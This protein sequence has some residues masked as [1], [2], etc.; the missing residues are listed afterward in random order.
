MTS[1]SS[2]AELFDAFE[3]EAFRL[4]TLDDYSQSGN[5]DAYRAFLA[6]EEKPD[7][8][9]SAWLNEVSRH[10]AAGKLVHRVHVLS[11]PLTPYLRFEL[12]WGYRTNSEAG[13]Q[14]FI[15]DVT[16]TPNPIAGAPDFWLMD[17]QHAAVMEYDDAGK[18]LGADVATDESGRFAS[19][20]EAAL[21]HA[22]P[23]VDWW[24]KYGE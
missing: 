18:F 22:E 21:A 19:Y 20:R 24:A 16:D 6:G 12:G 10:T 17:G 13:E 7:G 3:H 23:F 2:F 8:Y 11:R 15:L 1:S 9:N 4:E 5:V 14:F